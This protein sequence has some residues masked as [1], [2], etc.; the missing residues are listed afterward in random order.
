[1]VVILLSG[2]L[3]VWTIYCL[4]SAYLPIIEGQV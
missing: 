1:M 2:L 3:F 4:A